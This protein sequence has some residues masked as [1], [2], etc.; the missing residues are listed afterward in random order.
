MEANT[1]TESPLRR[2]RV[3]HGMSQR[4]LGLHLGIDQAA[5]SRLETGEYELR[6]AQIRILVAV[7]GVSADELLGLTSVPSVSA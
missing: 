4:Q 3:A 1:T 7:F 2:L 5:V 6:E